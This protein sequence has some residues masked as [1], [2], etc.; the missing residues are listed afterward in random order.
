M[1]LAAGPALRQPAILVMFGATV[2][3]AIQLITDWR[4]SRESSKE[5]EHQRQ[6]AQD[7]RKVDWRRT[8]YA[9]LLIQ[10]R[11]RMVEIHK[12]DPAQTS[13]LTESLPPDLEVLI[14]LIG[15]E[16]VFALVEDWLTE[17]MRLVAEASMNDT[18]AR[19]VR[20]GMRNAD[21]VKSTELYLGHRRRLD[22]L[23]TDIREACASE[24][25]GETVRRRTVGVDDQ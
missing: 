18:F 19:G 11:L 25:Q 10:L 16:R 14:D 7:A 21:L 23:W 20:E 9:D 3:L 4:R 8:V 5:R 17:R 6:L 13:L 15:S 2:T 12:S 22:A 24:L 1:V